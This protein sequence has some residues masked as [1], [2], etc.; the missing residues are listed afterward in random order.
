MRIK[1]RRGFS[2]LE[3]VFA[4]AL[5]ATAMIPIMQTSQMGIRR[6]G[7]NIHRITGTMLSNQLMERYR[8]MP[9]TWLEDSFGAG[10]VDM[11]EALEKDPVLGSPFLPDAYKSLLKKYEATASFEDVSGDSTMGLL[12]FDVKWKASAKAAESHLA[13]GKVVINYR[14]FGICTIGPQG[15][16]LQQGELSAFTLTSQGEAIPSACS[17][18]T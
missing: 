7:F 6:T 10:E 18:S 2:F 14:E 12:S 4:I 15:S 13:L 9:F 16:F 8:N 1:Q 5:L 11:K 17:G 3:I